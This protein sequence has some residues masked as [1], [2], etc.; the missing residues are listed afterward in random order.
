MYGW[1]ERI[2]TALQVFWSAFCDTALPPKS[3]T[4]HISSVWP[5]LL[6]SSSAMCSS[7]EQTALVSSLIP[8]PW[9]WLLILYIFFILCWDLFL[10]NCIC[11]WVLMFLRCSLC[12]FYAFRFDCKVNIRPQF[13]Q[14]KL[15]IRQIGI[16]PV[17]LFMNLSSIYL[18]H[19]YLCEKRV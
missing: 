11:G 10:W 6:L 3:R 12:G 9:V 4:G 18:F 13:G 1:A 19:V 17:C 8:P 15:N 5:Y 14:R 7:K 2:L 16:Q